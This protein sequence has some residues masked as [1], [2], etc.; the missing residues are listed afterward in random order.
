MTLIVQKYGG[1]SVATPERIRAVARRIAL[2]HQKGVSV[3]VVVSAMGHTTDELIDLAEKVSPSPSDREMDM[4]LTAG[5][6]ISMSLL[7]MAL[8]DLG[9][10][11]VSFTGSQAGIVTTRSHRRARIVRIQGDRVREA[12]R[13]GRVAIVAGFQGV[14]DLR[15]IT[16][17]G[18]GGSDT[19]AVAL[20]SV[21]QADQCEIFTDVDGVY[22]ADPRVVAGARMIS[23]LPHEL[24]VEL[25]TRGAG[26]LHPRS[27]ELAKQGNV[28]L[29]VKNSLKEPTHGQ[30]TLCT[31]LVSGADFMNQGLEE[32][33]VIG[34]TADAG[35]AR[36]WLQGSLDQ[37]SSTL[38]AFSKERQLAM[39]SAVFSSNSFEFF[40][41]RDA[42]HEW[43][44]W[45]EGLLKS[46]V[47]EAGGVDRET[48]P[49]SVVGERFTQDSAALGEVLTVLREAGIRPHGG[50]ISSLGL[51][52]GVVSSQAKT[53]VQALHRHFFPE[54]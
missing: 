53:A 20:A 35:K 17:L 41:E 32:L 26:V 6:R 25:A 18:R 38:C 28:R 48:V 1:T 23:K 36:V 12:I 24:M 2:E 52:V 54:A 37:V 15:E 50:S 13:S 4:L 40:C 7:S 10:A 27:V 33:R 19:T 47:I 3:V 5:E 11:A 21:L 22:S 51:T 44:S 46:A 8:A 31:E 43:D 45:I 39:V 9:V 49:V 29:L 14:S 42:A 30:G 16:T 34:V